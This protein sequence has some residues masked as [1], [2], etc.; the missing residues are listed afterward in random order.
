MSYVK[1]M[2]LSFSIFLLTPHLSQAQLSSS[3]WKGF[4]ATSVHLRYY[5][6]TDNIQSFENTVTVKDSPNGTY[7]MVCGWSQGYFGMQQLIDGSKVI[8]FS[9]WNKGSK[10]ARVVFKTSSVTAKTF[11]GEGTGF[12]SFYPFAWKANVPYSFKVTA[13]IVGS[14]TH[15][16]GWFKQSQNS[17]WIKLVTMAVPMNGVLLKGIYSFVE[18]FYRNGV[19]PLYIHK[20]T[21]GKPYIT[22]GNTTSRVTCATFTKDTNTDNHIDAGKTPDNN[23]FLAT[24]GTTTNITTKIN[25]KMCV[26]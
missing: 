3:D 8:I 19:G 14:E 15:Y 22:I 17:N 7:F 2:F 20:A 13:E 23:W 25:S 24:G 6:T 5:T 1:F 26:N 21:F 10:N 18:D 16:T 9:L 4:A 11:S 12:Q